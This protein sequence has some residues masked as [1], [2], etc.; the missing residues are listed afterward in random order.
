[1][2][3]PTGRVD[4]RLRRYW[5][6]GKTSGESVCPIY[7]SYHNAEFMLDVV[8]DSGQASSEDAWPKDDS[9][10]PTCCDCGREFPDSAAKQLFVE[11]LW[12]RDTGE[13]MRLRDAPPGAMYDA[14][15]MHDLPERCGPDGRCLMVVCPGGRTWQIDGRASNCTMPNDN[16]HK[17]WCRHGEPPNLTVD[18]NGKTCAAGAGS[19]QAGDYHGFLVNGVF[20]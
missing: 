6:E 1:M 14:D 17:C 16:E 12:K 2:L 15:W 5:S 3:T 18:K 19:I 20:T 7:G 4:R 13:E 10:W 8:P 11:H 9:R